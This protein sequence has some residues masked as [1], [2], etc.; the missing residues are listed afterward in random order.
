MNT[1]KYA[2]ETH[3]FI[4]LEETIAS[5]KRVTLPKRTRITIQTLQR[6]LPYIKNSQTYTVSNGPTEGIK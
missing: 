3:D 2:I 6:F 4:L 5:T 1:L